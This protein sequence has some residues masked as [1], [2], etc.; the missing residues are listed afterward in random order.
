LLEL[1]RFQI[2]DPPPAG[3]RF[4]VPDPRSAASWPRSRLEIRQP[5]G[6][7][8]RQLGTFFVLGP[9]RIGSFYV[10]PDPEN[11]KK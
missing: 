6:K 3:A 1:E 10:D 8:R 5:L 2:Q 9:Q 11:L 7:I 4:T